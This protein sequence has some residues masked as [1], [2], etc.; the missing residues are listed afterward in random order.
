MK[1]LAPFALVGLFAR[2]ASAVTSIEIQGSQ[3]VNPKTNERF[4]IVGVDYQPGGGK[5]IYAVSRV[6]LG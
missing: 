6:V 1:T 3:F 4:V 2:L 5:F